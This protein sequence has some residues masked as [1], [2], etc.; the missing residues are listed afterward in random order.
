MEAP[1]RPNNADP[2]LFRYVATAEESN[3]PSITV[4]LSVQG[5]LIGGQIISA[6]LYAAALKPGAN[7]KDA[8]TVFALLQ[9]DIL[10]ERGRYIH[11]Q[12]PWVVSV[13]GQI[14]FNPGSVWRCRLDAVNGFFLGPVR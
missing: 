12:N 4:V 1:N 11:L 8:A 14:P 13:A 9:Q 5:A 2:L 7:V 3:Q 10:A 6:A